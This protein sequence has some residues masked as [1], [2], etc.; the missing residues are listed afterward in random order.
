[1]ICRYFDT[2]VRSNPFKLVSIKSLVG[3]LQAYFFVY[4]VDYAGSII[5]R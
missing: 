2:E 4:N 3:G 5:Q 1:M